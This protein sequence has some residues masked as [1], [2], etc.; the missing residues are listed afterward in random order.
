MAFVTFDKWLKKRISANRSHF[1][2]NMDIEHW[3][4]NRFIEYKGNLY[5]PQ[6]ID[7]PTGRDYGIL[8]VAPIGTT[9]KLQSGPS[10]TI[11][12]VNPNQIRIQISKEV[13]KKKPLI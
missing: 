3:P 13:K 11:I 6:H 9:R 1:L 5:K 2:K 4:T 7:W 10:T 12:P 8:Y